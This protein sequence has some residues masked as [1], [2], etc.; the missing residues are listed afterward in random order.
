MVVICKWKK[1]ASRIITL[2][3]A[4][5][6]KNAPMLL[7][8]RMMLAHGYDLRHNQQKQERG[9]KLLQNQGKHTFLLSLRKYVFTEF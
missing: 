6:M 1:F 8:T 5:M 2:I 7:T 4:L 3:P 9:N